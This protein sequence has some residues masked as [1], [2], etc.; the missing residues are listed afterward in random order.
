MRRARSAAEAILAS[1]A[2]SSTVEK[3]IVPAIVCRCR[4]VS[5]KG[6]LSSSSP[7]ACGTSTK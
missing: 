6:A 1:S 2:P 3:R 4:K 5:R 7:A